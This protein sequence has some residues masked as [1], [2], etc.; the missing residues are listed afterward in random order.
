MKIS[1]K[2]ST[3][4]YLRTGTAKQ[5]K[6]YTLLIEHRIMQ[7]LE[8]STPVLADTIPIN[9]DIEGSDL[10]IICYFENIDRFKRLVIEN[11]G[12]LSQF[13]ISN[14]IING[15]ETIV[16]T[17]T[18]NGFELEIFGQNIPVKQQ[19]AYR[20]L[21]VEDMLLKKRGEDFRQKII[22]LKKQGYKTEPAFAKLLQ[23]EGNPYQA[24]LKLANVYG[25]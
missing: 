2:F 3:I 9:I 16:A 21:L 19:D 20:H 6:A 12:H 10:D 17:M 25:Y 14:R 23:L 15:Q 4:D 18:A 7:I 8:A 24:L 1:C 13:S 11:F 22:M 5:K